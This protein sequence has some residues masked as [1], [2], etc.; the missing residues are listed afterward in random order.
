MLLWQRNYLSKNHHGIGDEMISFL[1][2]LFTKP[3]GEEVM[4]GYQPE[5]QQVQSNSNVK[6]ISTNSDDDLRGDFIYNCRV[7]C[8]QGKEVTVQVRTTVLTERPAFHCPFCNRTI[9]LPHIPK[10]KM[11]FELP[12]GEPT[13]PGVVWTDKT[14]HDMTVTKQIKNTVYNRDNAPVAI[15]EKGEFKYLHHQPPKKP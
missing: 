1:K 10:L 14:L 3:D 13:F 5:R 7:Q 8:S 11:V 4:T 9:K 6:I 12:R 15:W 2:K